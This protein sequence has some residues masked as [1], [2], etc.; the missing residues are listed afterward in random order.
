MGQVGWPHFKAVF[1]L[2]A[3]TGEGVDPLRGFLAKQAQPTDRLRFD[4]SIATRRHPKALCVDYVRSELLDHCP[5]DIA[6]QVTILVK[7]LGFVHLSFAIFSVF[8][9]LTIFLRF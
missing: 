3:L 8:K 5:A 1:F 7:F 2:S 9:I 4:P 6:Y